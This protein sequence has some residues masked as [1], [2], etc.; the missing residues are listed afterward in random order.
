MKDS[1]VHLNIKVM[2]STCAVINIT[3]SKLSDYALIIPGHH[4]VVGAYDIGSNS[5]LGN[6]AIYFITFEDIAIIQLQCYV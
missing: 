2:C 3:N 4:F 1:F 5:D 6:G